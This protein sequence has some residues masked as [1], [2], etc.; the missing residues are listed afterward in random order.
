MTHCFATIHHCQL[1]IFAGDEQEPSCHA[2]KNLHQLCMA[3]RNVACLS[4]PCHHC[5]NTPPTASL[6]SHPLFGL[7]KFSA[8]INECQWA[9][10]FLHGEIH[11]Y[12]FFLYALP[13]TILSDYS[14]AAIFHMATE[15][16]GILVGRFNLC[17]HTANTHL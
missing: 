6:C 3:I 4:H 7:Q 13:D 9:P 17:C 2:H 8:S 1:C 14:F 11:F 16:N 15:C 12:T 5:W 10:S